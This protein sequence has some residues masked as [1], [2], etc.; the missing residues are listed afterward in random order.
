MHLLLLHYVNYGSHGNATII[1]YVSFFCSKSP[2]NIQFILITSIS[3]I[4]FE[5]ICSHRIEHIDDHVL[6]MSN[7][8]KE[9]AVCKRIID[10]VIAHRRA[11]ELVYCVFFIS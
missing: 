4:K 8:E 10:V 1:I 3:R 9:R 11:T 7:C 6:C 5:N 2:G